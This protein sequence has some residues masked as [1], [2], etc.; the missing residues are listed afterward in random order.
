MTKGTKGK[1]AA[2]VEQPVVVQEETNVNTNWAVIYDN[3]IAKMTVALKANNTNA[4]KQTVA[5]VYREYEMTDDLEFKAVLATLVEKLEAL[6]DLAMKAKK[7]K[8]RLKDIALAQQKLITC[9]KPTN[10]GWQGCG[11][12]GHTITLLPND[13]VETHTCTVC[14]GRGTIERYRQAMDILEAATPE[15]VAALI[16]DVEAFK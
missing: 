6:D 1:S 16:A 2:Q 13:E 15:V 5:N 3:N 14:Q 10:R 7:A 9:P 4:A 11:G 8:A 12:I